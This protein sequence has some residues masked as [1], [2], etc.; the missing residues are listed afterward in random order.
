MGGMMPFGNMMNIGKLAGTDKNAPK[1]KFSDVIGM[2]EVKQE[3]TEVVD[4]LKNPA[5]YHK[6][7]AK[8]PR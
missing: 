1:T 7:G 6:I 8:I 4:F 3:L 2:E 5:K